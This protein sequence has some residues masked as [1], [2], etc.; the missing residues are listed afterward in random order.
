[1]YT[2][3]RRPASFQNQFIF[4]YQERVKNGLSNYG[5][6]HLEEMLKNDIVKCQKGIWSF[7]NAE[8]A[9]RARKFYL[10]TL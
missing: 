4:N 5:P 6:E 2:D 8:E 3:K 1:M 10:Q 7:T 9:N